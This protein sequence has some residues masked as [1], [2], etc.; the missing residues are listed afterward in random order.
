MVH[1]SIYQS[2]TSGTGSQSHCSPSIRISLPWDQD[3]RALCVW[4]T[5]GIHIDLY[6]LRLLDPLE[7]QLDRAR[8]C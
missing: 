3:D 5:L 4:Y 6:R 2:A 1:L 8:E 7:R